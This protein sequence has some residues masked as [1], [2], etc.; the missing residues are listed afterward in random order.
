MRRATWIIPVLFLFVSLSSRADG[1]AGRTLAITIDDLPYAPELAGPGRI[2]DARRATAAILT[3]LGKHHAPAIGFVNESR[4]F[5]PGEMDARVAVLRQWSD[6]GI[7]L[8]NHTFSHPRLQDTPVDRYEDDIVRGDIV[9]RRLRE[10]RGGPGDRP[11]FFRYPFNSTG[12]TRE[13]RQAVEQF[14]TARGYRIAPFTVEHADYLFNRI[15]TDPASDDALRTRTRDAYMAQLDT[16]LDFMEHLSRDIFGREIPQILLIHA[17][18]LNAECL[19]A[20]LTRLEARGYRII[21]LKEALRDPAYATPD[22]YVGPAG[23]SWLHRWSIHLGLPMRL[24]DEP[25]PPQWAL[26]LY[27]RL[28]APAH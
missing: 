24:R 14:L 12:P 3:A 19:D 26:D 15:W 7:E 10:E 2:E 8:G 21:P 11:L 6:A 9:T 27:Q 4:L 1:P 25:D 17:N 28:T 13:A 18:D 20:M 22:D 23:I 16:M 5:V